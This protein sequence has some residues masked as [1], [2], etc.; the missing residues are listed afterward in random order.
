MS[1][2]GVATSIWIDEP[3]LAS[4]GAAVADEDGALVVLV[5]VIDGPLDDVSR[6]ADIGGVEDKAFAVNDVVVSEVTVATSSSARNAIF[7]MCFID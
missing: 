3:F 1:H 7:A 2:D 5:R 4:N 6:D